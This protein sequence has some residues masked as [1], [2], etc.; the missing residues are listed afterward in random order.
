[1]C[2]HNLQ[3]LTDEHMTH[4]IYLLHRHGE[5]NCTRICRKYL[6]ALYTCAQQY[7][8]SECYHVVFSRHSKASVQQRVCD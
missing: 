1:M 5:A 8:G 4:N 6:V 7:F 3:L 2:N